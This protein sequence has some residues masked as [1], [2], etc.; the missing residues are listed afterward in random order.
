MVSGGAGDDG[1]Y[2]GSKSDLTT[3]FLDEGVATADAPTFLIIIEVKLAMYTFLRACSTLKM[4]L[5]RGRDY[6]SIIWG[7]LMDIGM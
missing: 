5:C 1:L 3:A 4:V 7:A 2:T 6:S